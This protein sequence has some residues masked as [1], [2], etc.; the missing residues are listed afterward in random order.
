MVTF[1]KSQRR[2]GEVEEKTNKK[3]GEKFVSKKE[4]KPKLRE[5]E[6]KIGGLGLGG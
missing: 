5:K 3:M 4:K 6:E 1:A 2:Y